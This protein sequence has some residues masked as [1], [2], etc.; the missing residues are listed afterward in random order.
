M[1]TFAYDGDGQRATKTVGG[2][3][4]YFLYDGDEVLDEVQKTPSGYQVTTTYGWGA[5]GLVART[6]L[7][8]SI[9]Q[10]ARGVAD[11][12]FQ[13]NC[14]VAGTLVEMADG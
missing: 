6:S 12:L 5:D 4:T 3:T 2:V 9:G 11:T 10:F 14:F 1:G 8:R 7:G 13:R